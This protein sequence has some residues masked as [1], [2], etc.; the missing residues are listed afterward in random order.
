MIPGRY[1]IN[2][3]QIKIRE[4]PIEKCPIRLEKVKSTQPTRNTKG[5]FR[6]P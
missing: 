6:T 3:G 1:E 5:L 2:G 4:L